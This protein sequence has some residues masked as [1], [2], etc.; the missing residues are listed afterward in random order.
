MISVGHVLIG[1]ATL[2]VSGVMIVAGRAPN[3]ELG[4]VFLGLGLL[5]MFAAAAFTWT[6]VLVLRRAH[7]GRGSPLSLSL[8][9]VEL[10]AGAALAAGLALAVEGYGAF[11]P[12]R[13]PL[14]LPSALLVA[15]GLAGLALEVM[16]RR[17]AAPA[18]P[19]LRGQEDRPRAE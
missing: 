6:A 19:D 13:S 12:W 17:P 10:V 2:V 18:S 8:V 3:A 7:H 1:G 14:L 5:L 15:H 11:Q 4:G 9:I 16:A